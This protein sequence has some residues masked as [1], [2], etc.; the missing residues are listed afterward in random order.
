MTTLQVGGE[1]G[2]E[3]ERSTSS[4]GVLGSAPEPV[5]RF[6]ASRHN[7]AFYSEL[8]SKSK[9]GGALTLAARRDDNSDYDAFTTYRAGLTLPAGE[10]SR[11]H[12]S[13]S[14]AFNAPAFNQLRA[15]LYTV[16][17]PDLKPERARSWEVGAEQ[18]M[19]DGL[20]RLGATFFNQRFS[21]MIQYVS[22][23]PPD[24]LG[25]YDN[26]TR[27]ESNG[28][29][30]EATVT[31]AITW[32]ANASYTLAKPRVSE[33]DATYS[34]DLKVGDPL[35]RRPR[36]S[37]TATIAWSRPQTGSFSVV[38]NY[39]GDRPDY[40]FNQFPSPVVTLPAYTKIDVAASRTIF[41]AASG[42]GL[43]ATLRVDN[44]LDRN[45][46]DVLHYPA[47]RRTYLVGARLSGSM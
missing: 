19:A 35:V 33:L 39:I 8:Q 22:G 18:T 40:D 4:F 14:T 12:A 32:S 13:I 23:G 45:Y 43:S 44:I 20:L 17:S 26:L 21:D 36:K 16:A 2:S 34:G 25:S 5:S 15:T 27:A 11:V 10:R 3:S 1:Y 41:R 47:P 46:E 30:L 42:L 28:Y 37:A 31:P 38:A 6:K 7:T 9:T 24:F 29:E